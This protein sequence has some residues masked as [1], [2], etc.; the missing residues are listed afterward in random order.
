MATPAGNAGR[1]GRPSLAGFSPQ[2]KG[3]AEGK[4]EMAGLSAVSSWV[5]RLAASP[6]TMC[7]GFCPLWMNIANSP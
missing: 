6:K 4:D 7:R 5:S 2:V 1:L 3:G